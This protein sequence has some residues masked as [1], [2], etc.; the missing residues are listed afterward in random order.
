MPNGY[1]DASFHAEGLT[2]ERC[3]DPEVAYAVA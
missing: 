2:T 1:C 3:A